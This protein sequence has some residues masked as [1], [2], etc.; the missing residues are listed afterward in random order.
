MAMVAPRSKV[1]VENVAPELAPGSWINSPPLTLASLR[2]KV[3]VIDFWAFQCINCRHVLPKFQS[4][5]NKYHNKDVVF[6]GIH[7]PETAEERDLPSL[8][9]FVEDNNI[10]LPV[11]ADNSYKNWDQYNVEFWPS[12][13]LIDKKG[14]IRTFHFGELGFSSLENSIQTLV[15]E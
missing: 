4:W 14:V 10:S 7:T 1:L 8:R 9:K 15:N 13:F 12:T 3:V 5:Y 11:L 2:G 6:I